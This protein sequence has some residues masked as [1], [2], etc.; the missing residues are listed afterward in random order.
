MRYCYR[1]KNK[2]QNLKVQTSI[3]YP[4]TVYLKSTAKQF[5][6]PVFKNKCGSR[7]NIPEQDWFQNLIS[8]TK[9]VLEPKFWNS[10]GSRTKIQE[11]VR[12]QNHTSRTFQAGSRTVLEVQ[13]KFKN[14]LEL[15]ICSRTFFAGEALHLAI[16][17]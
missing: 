11:L 15:D 6:E 10:I 5:L 2:F 12:F 4:N 13:E 17:N 7:T 3:V 8:G 1:D 14:V 16:H 9:L